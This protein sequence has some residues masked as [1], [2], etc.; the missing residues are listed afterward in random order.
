MDNK[1]TAVGAQT[2]TAEK[3]GIDTTPNPS[4]S[5][6]ENQYNFTQK[7]A[8]LIW[9]T[10]CTLLGQQEGVELKVTVSQR[11]SAQAG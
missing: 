3:K 4:F 6:H 11:K 5:I 10:M 8:Q 2:L 9:D 1:K 7:T